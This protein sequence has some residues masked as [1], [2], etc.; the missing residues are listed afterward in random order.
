MSPIRGT[1]SG[2]FALGLLLSGAAAH[3]EEGEI[4]LGLATP[5]LVYTK[6]TEEDY[7][8][9]REQIVWQ[10]GVGHEVVGEVGYGVT[11]HLNVGGLFRVYGT[12]GILQ[13]R[14]GAETE[15]SST[16]FAIGPKLDYIILP[17]DKV[18]P[19]VGAVVGYQ[20]ASTSVDD[21][22]ATLSGLTFMARGGIRAFPGKEFSIDPW[23][24]LSY[25][26]GSREDDLYGENDVSELDL[27]IYLGI[28]GWIH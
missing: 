26:T 11:A 27:G 1:V 24:G 21:L 13:P 7:S 6:T 22:E 4:Q 17:G 9:D 5:F 28:S 16:G 2:V 23:L 20:R 3:A 12:A 15:V 10:W 19:F 25:F 18:Q 14:N 8:F